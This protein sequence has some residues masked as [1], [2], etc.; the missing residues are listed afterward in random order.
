MIQS[1]SFVFGCV[2]AV[3]A[4]ALLFWVLQWHASSYLR[5]RKARQEYG[6]AYG[7]SYPLGLFIAALA[8]ATT[9]GLVS[10][11]LFAI[12]YH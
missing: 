2:F 12:A 9:S 5:V 6:I 4:L 7:G 1:P 3:V 10:M 11:L 8:G